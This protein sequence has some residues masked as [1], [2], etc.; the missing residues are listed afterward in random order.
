MIIR[1][2]SIAGS[3]RQVR[4]G[5]HARSRMIAGSRH[6]NNM[7]LITT[8][9][10][11]KLAENVGIDISLATRRVSNSASS[12]TDRSS[13]LRESLMPTTVEGW[14]VRHADLARCIPRSK[15]RPRYY[16]RLLPETMLKGLFLCLQQLSFR[17]H[18]R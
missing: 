14:S 1:S 7:T 8:S 17:P 15:C 16:P 18:F 12:L 6:L 11:A 2:K 5:L 13:L 4:D 9:I 10:A 3:D